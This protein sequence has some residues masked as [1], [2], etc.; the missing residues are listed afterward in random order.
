MN[1]NDDYLVAR[2]K[3][4]DDGTTVISYYKVDSISK[5]ES[6]LKCHVVALISLDNNT[7]RQSV[8][9]RRPMYLAQA[10]LLSFKK[11]DNAARTFTRDN[12]PYLLI[13]G[14]DIDDEHKLLI[15]NNV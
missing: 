6:W 2:S 9:A 10:H 8:I 12:I 4:D 11:L 3:Y 14:Y 1:D 15:G 7:G 13:R 5:N